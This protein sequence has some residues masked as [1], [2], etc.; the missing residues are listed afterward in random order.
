MNQ[1]KRARQQQMRIG[2]VVAAVAVVGA[3]G[4]L[5]ISHLPGRAAGATNSKAA[6][7]AATAHVTANA[8]TAASTATPVVCATQKIP[9][10]NGTPTT[11][12]GP[13]AVSGTLVTG[14]QC[15]QYV[16][17]KPGSGPAIKAGDNVTVNYTGWLSTGQKFD[18]SLAPGRTPFQVQNVG[19]AGVIQG[20]NMGLIG[21]KA[22]GE[23]RLVIPY[24]L[25]YGAGGS[26][27][28]IP[29]YAT[30][31]FDITVVSIP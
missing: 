3:L 12:G 31:I 9:G 13:P 23:R 24:Q 27:P 25:G 6:K 20:W 18:S 11:S 7:P 15:L 10:L 8:T 4:W 19:Q 2:S 21:M 16:D 22:G 14:D 17:I 5:L 1:R 28:S 30:L 26:P 29:G